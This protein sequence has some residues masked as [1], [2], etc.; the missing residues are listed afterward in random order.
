MPSIRQFFRKFI[1]ISKF[2]S[3]NDLFICGVFVSDSDILQNRIVKQGNILEYDGI[4]RKQCFRVNLGYIHT[5]HGNLS[6]VNIPEPCSQPGYGCFS[7]AGWFDQS[8]NLSLLCRKGDIF[9]Y[10]FSGIVGK[11]D[12]VKDNIIPL[13]GKPVAALLD[14]MIENLIHTGNVGSCTDDC[15]KILERALQ[16]VIQTGYHQ[17][18]HKECKHGQTAL[19]EQN[20]SQQRN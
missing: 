7:A 15:R 6:S 17:K 4:Q 13:I 16:R 12:M 14:G 19:Y 5:S 18:E 3:S 2:R 10:S 1:Y 8:R 11:S 9:Q 20:S